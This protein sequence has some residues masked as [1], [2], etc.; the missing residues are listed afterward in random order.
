MVLDYIRF[1]AHPRMIVAEVKE[2]PTKQE[3]TGAKALLQ[4]YMQDLR[5]SYFLYAF[6]LI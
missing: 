2:Q 1:D 4:D 3:A 6:S 5:V